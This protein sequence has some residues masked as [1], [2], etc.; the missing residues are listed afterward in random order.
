MSSWPRYSPEEIQAV[1]QVL[2]AGRVNYW[3]G[4]EGRAF[5]REFAA[6]HHAPYGVAVANGTVALE[7]ALH[8]LGVGPG[9]DVVVPS[10]TFLASVSSII[11]QGARPVFADV[12]PDTGTITAQTVR[13]ALTPHTRAIV[14]VHLAGWPCDMDALRALADEKRLLLIEDC[15]QAH[16]ATW[17][18]RPVGSQGDA[19]AFSFCT[20]KIMSTGGEGGMVLFHAKAA[21]RRAWSYKDHG[22]SWDAVQNMEHRP[23]FRWLH[24]SIGT[25]WRL[26]EMQ[27]AIGRVQLGELPEWLARRRE[28]AQILVER[29]SWLPGL[30]VP[31]P[32]A[33]VGHAYYKFYA[34]VRPERLRPGWDRNRIVQ[35]I[36]AQGVTCLHGGCSEVYLERAF[37]GTGYRPTKR[38]PVARDLGET[39]LMFLVDHTH[40]TAQMHQLADV[41]EAVMHE[42]AAGEPVALRSAIIG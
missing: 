1:Q 18:G 2:A 40:L 19:A 23:G 36:Q 11:V 12:D 26:T 10:R 3:N 15:A 22:K 34:Y 17:R 8:A 9:D 16:G 4:E 27:A 35:A 39:S 28:N 37:D 13:E 30:R 7:L 14:A 38:L 6:F 32:P 42:A 20:D 21:W 33:G 29:L 31:V 24:E 25:N 41:V 5:E